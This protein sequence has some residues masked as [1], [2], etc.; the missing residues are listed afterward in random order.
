[1]TEIQQTNIAVANFIIGELYKDKPFNLVLNA[2][3]TG[4]LYIIASESHH[5]HSDFV[6]KLEATLR[7]RV[8]N[9]TG[10]IL[11]V[12]DSNADLY[13]HI[14]SIYIEKHQKPENCIDQFIASGGFDKAFES[15]FGR[16]DDV[17]NAVRGGK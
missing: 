5:L 8:N 2:G 16:S 3:Q 17:V 7:Q 15:V 13:Y 4:S 6:Q 1:M 9:G 10:I 12:S 14:L 11:E